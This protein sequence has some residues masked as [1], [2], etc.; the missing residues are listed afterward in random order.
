MK[1]IYTLAAGGDFTISNTHE[2]QVLSDVGEDTIYVCSKCEHAENKEISKLKDGDKC[3]RCGEKISEEKSIEVGNIFPLGTKYSEALGLNFVDTE[4]NKKPVVMGSYGIGISRLLGTVVEINNDEKGI[5]W[6]ENIAPYK[7]YLISLEQNDEA[8]KIY[9]E[10]QKSGMDVLYDDRDGK[11]AGEKFADADLIGCPVRIVVSR[12][13]LEKNS[14]EVKLRNKKE[15]EL[16]PLGE[17]VGY[18][19]A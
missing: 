8:D 5:I 6:P 16:M 7:V 12:K 18:F 4:G 9:D 13:T 3:P 17:V 10:L 11:T 2:F 15:A 19:I 14:V 1:A